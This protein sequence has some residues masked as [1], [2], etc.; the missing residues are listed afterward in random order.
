MCVKRC[1]WTRE[2]KKNH[3]H[4]TATNPFKNGG[5][6]GMRGASH[7]H[8][9]TAYTFAYINEYLC[10]CNARKPFVRIQMTVIFVFSLSLT[11]Y[12]IYFF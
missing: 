8:K 2:E 3:Q 9:H 7:T 10:K 4:H 1:N 6:G 12:Y 11:L 5:A